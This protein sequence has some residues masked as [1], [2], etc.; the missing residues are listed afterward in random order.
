MLTFHI[1]NEVFCMLIE[2]FNILNAINLFSFIHFRISY[3]S[4]HHSETVCKHFGHYL[5]NR[6]IYVNSLHVNQHIFST[7]DNFLHYGQLLSICWIS[8]K[9]KNQ[10]KMC[11]C[12]ILKTVSQYVAYSTS[13]FPVEGV[14]LY[15][16]AHLPTRNLQNC[17]SLKSYLGSQSQSVLMNNTSTSLY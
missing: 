7:K 8:Q 14:L 15:M 3:S 17:I 16:T 6:T 1:K 10:T 12:I 4:V 9:K 11:P 13:V 2:Y 5:F